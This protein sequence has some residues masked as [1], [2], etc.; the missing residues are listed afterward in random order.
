MSKI[1]DAA[2]RVKKGTDK[3]ADAAKAGARKTG[4]ALK[5]A[6]KAVKKEGR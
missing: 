5:D 2:A 3:V 6:G 4:Q 1:D